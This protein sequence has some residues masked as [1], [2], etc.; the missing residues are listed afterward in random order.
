MREFHQ[1]AVSGNA[2]PA[3]L[4]AKE[5]QVGTRPA[6]LRGRNNSLDH[7]GMQLQRA[8]DHGASL[9]RDTCRSFT[10]A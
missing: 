8:V 3:F 10:Q 9:S 7:A 6:R 2:A 5:S 4:R 1:Q